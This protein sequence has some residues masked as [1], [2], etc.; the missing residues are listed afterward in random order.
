MQESKFTIANNERIARDTFKMTLVGDTSAIK[1]SGQFVQVAVDGCFLRRPISVSDFE[2][3]ILTLVYKVV[4][5]GTEVMSGMSSYDN[6]SLITGLGNGFD[7]ERTQNAALLVGGSVGTAPLL[8]L[9]KQLVRRGCKV[10]VAL[11]FASG[12]SV[13]YEKEFKALGAKVAIATDDGTLGVKGLVTKAIDL[14]PDDYDF[15]YACGPKVM[16][17]ALCETLEAPGQV[18]MEERMGCGTGICYGCTIK[19]MDGPRRVCADG[20][21][22][23]KEDI[24][25]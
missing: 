4:G 14:I 19:T 23:D 15:F 11:G 18:S 17:K 24:V 9:A 5:K 8:L 3:G 25:W 10:M 20:P 16:L 13:F 6:V 2:D 7:P 22:F 1:A 21:V 12:D